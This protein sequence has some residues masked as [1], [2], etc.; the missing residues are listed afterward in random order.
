M[1][2]VT[3]RPEEEKKRKRLVLLILLLLLLSIGGYFMYQHFNQPETPVTVVSGE[4]LPEG[5]DAKEISEKELQNMAQKKVDASQFNMVIAPNVTV[6]KDRN[7]N[8]F[9]Q[10]PKHNANPVNVEIRLKD[11]DELVYTS[12]AIQPG[13]EI[14]GATLEKELGE[15]SYPAT[16]L[17]S[18]YDNATKEKRG[19][20]AATVTFT[21]EK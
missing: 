20:V 6:T 12:G 1:D 5:K 19:Q 21:I 7:S 13:Y 15:G 11:S 18:I 3:K 2:E 8:L 10:N 16:A 9:I 14:K 17:F 4:F